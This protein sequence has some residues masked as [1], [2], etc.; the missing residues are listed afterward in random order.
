MPVTPALLP[1]RWAA[2]LALCLAAAVV[3]VA[4]GPARAQEEH[5]PAP[6]GYVELRDG[7]LIAV[8]IR[9]PIGFEEGRRYPT[10]FEMSGYESGSAGDQT[11]L[12]QLYDQA[13]GFEGP[14]AEGSRQLT[15]IFYNNYVTVHASVRGT[16]CSSGEFDLFSW[17][18]ALDGREMIEWIADQPWSNGRVGYYSHSYG[19]YTGFMIAATRPPHLR[20]IS[21]SGLI[22]DLYRGITYPGGV[23]NY[24]FP[25]LWAV[26]VRNAYDIAGGTG[27]ALVTT[28]DQQCAENLLTHT[29][30]PAE[31]PVVQ[32]ASG[33]TDSPWFR[34]RSLVKYA[35]RID[36]PI[37]ITGAW[38]DEQTGPR[39][40]HLFELIHGVPKRMLTTNGDHGT[41]TGSA[42][43][44]SD[45]RSWLDHWVRGVDRGFGSLRQDRSS[46]TTLFEMHATDDG[47]ESNGQKHT[48]TFPLEDTRWT[49]YYLRERGRLAKSAPEGSEASD[50]YVSGTGRQSWSYQAGPSFGPPF[51]TEDGPDELSYRSAPVQRDVAIAGPMT[52]TLYVS[53]TAPDTE[54]FVQ[55]IDEAPDGSRTYIQ[56][57]LLRASHRR[58]DPARS[59][60]VRSDGRRIMY[61]PYRPHD[62]TVMITPNQVYRYV[63]EVFPAG[64]VFREGHRIL[65]KVSAPPRV[66]SYYAYVPR[67]LPSVNTLLH[68]A[69]HPS[70]LMLPVAP[71]RGVDLGAPIPCGG[72]TAV[73]CV[74]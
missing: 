6:T 13:G 38:Q 4:D 34:K 14:L 62:E 35:R 37:H 57:G 71:L 48:R 53:S 24:G 8:N 72:L 44:W 19:G 11:V 52:A 43:V 67:V 20:A 60:W 31:D 1:R 69:E 12:G 56:R 16:G 65:I 30:D 46:V 54:L 33:D 3:V 51:T 49:N 10:I 15:K 29:R 41:Q 7:T 40:P 26:G 17:R 47:L 28:Q 50:T 2:V 42:E 36:I 55:L 64:H 70:R 23:S 59:D 18:S 32:G 61:R 73:R 39:F 21:V 66:D 63:V 27:Q 22:D 74:A 68:D 58:I 5:P 9:M 45:R 25:L